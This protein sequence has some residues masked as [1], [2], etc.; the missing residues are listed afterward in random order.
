LIF[1]GGYMK[2]MTLKMLS[3]ILIIAGMALVMPVAADLVW[4]TQTVNDVGSAGQFNALAF[5][6]GD[7]PCISYYDDANTALMYAYY[8]GITWQKE[9]VDNTGDVGFYTSLAFDGSDNPVISYYDQTNT[10]LKFAWYD[11][12]AWHNTTVEHRHHRDQLC[13]FIRRFPEICGE[14]RG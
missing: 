4:Q 8:D 14:E 1:I 2:K 7:H 12:A 3:A 9:M 11:G 6:S 5:D 10:A 13:E